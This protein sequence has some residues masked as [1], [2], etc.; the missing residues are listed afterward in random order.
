MIDNDRTMSISMNRS[1][2]ILK[3]TKLRINARPYFSKWNRSTTAASKKYSERVGRDAE[4]RRNRVDREDEVGQLDEDQDEEQRRRHRPTRFDDEKVLSVEFF[5]E[6]QQAPSATDD[7]ILLAVELF[8]ALDPHADA[9]DDE[10]SAEHIEN[11][12]EFRD[13]RGARGDK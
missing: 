11:P 7:P 9:G 1:V 3:P 2:S 6:R 4:D 10:H 12:V 8:V 13:E 5:R